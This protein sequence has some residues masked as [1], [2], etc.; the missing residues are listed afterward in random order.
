MRTR[1]I[2]Q[3]FRAGGAVIVTVGAVCAAVG[4]WSAF[5]KTSPGG[6]KA[7]LDLISGAICFAIAALMVRFGRDMIS[8]Y[9][10]K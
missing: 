2:K 10:I 6:V 5:F 9:R 7:V 8:Y 3:L 4:I 1:Q